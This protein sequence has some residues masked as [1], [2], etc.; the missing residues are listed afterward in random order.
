[1]KNIFIV[2]VP[3]SGKTTLARMIKARYP[4]YNYISFEA[5]RNGFIKA[6]PELDMGNRNSDARKLVMPSFILEYAK[7]NSVITGLPT[8]VDYAFSSIEVLCEN[9]GDDDAIICLGYGGRSID[10]VVGMIKEN[11]LEK[12]YTY[13][14]DIDKIK[15]HFHDMILDDKKNMM[16]CER[17]GIRYY[18]T[19]RREESLEEV[20]RDIARENGK[21]R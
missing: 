17:L 19:S 9:M 20:M 4:E 18:D 21:L 15:T 2:G 8:L 11:S 1:M 14:W 13:D 6:L 16:E 3:R 10:E 5:L 7:W 12:D